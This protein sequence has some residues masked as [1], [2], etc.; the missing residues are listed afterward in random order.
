MF[1]FRTLNK[2]ETNKR[3]PR[4]NTAVRLNYDEVSKDYSYTTTNTL[5]TAGTFNMPTSYHSGVG[6]RGEY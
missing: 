2:K 1:G 4:G 6:K 3:A 5:Y